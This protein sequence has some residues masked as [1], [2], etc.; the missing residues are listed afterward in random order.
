MLGVMSETLD[1]ELESMSGDEDFFSVARTMP[2]VAVQGE[3]IVL[4]CH[5]HADERR[6]TFDAECCHTL[7]DCVQSIFWRAVSGAEQ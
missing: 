4:E 5:V 1:D 2:F 7:V 6:R 3:I